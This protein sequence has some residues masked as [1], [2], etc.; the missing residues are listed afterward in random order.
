MNNKQA[1]ENIIQFLNRAELRGNEVP[2]FVECMRFLSS[3]ANE[4]KN[5]NIDNKEVPKEKKQ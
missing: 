5:D 2:A 1:I 3:L 4:N